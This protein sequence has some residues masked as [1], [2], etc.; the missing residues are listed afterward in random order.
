MEI[1][2]L[3]RERC[4][5]L[6]SVASGESMQKYRVN[7]RMRRKS[8]K[9]NINRRKVDEGVPSVRGSQVLRAYYARW[10]RHARLCE[11]YPT[12]CVLR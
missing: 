4:K 11:A 7:E 5:T 6:S 1:G 2:S 9:I 10:Q 8:R 3:K 12:I